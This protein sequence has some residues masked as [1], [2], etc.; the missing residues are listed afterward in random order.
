VVERTLLI[1]KPDSVTARKTGDVLK[2]IEGAGFVIREMR[3]MRLTLKE[4]SRFYDVHR[5]KPFYPS[6]V[7][8]MTSGPCVPALLERENAISFLREFIGKTNP[9]EAASGSI[10]HDLGTD[11]QRNAV[12][13]SDGPDTAKREI[14]FFFGLSAK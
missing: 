10:R 12:H 8:F 3:M 13:A 9:A 6:L 4:A 2:R 7:E 11:I 1:V 5:G 14:L